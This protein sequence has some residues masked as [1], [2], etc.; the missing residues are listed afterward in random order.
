MTSDEATWLAENIELIVE[1]PQ[2]FL[3]RQDYFDEPAKYDFLRSIASEELTHQAQAKEAD[4]VE[5]C[6]TNGLDR[7][8]G[9]AKYLFHTLV[10]TIEALAE[11]FDGH[12]SR[13]VDLAG[14]I[15]DLRRSILALDQ[16]LHN[17]ITS[18]Q[19]AVDIRQPAASA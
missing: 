2:E 3:H 14:Q 1:D 18:K 6:S 17:H 9:G 19:Q 16:V 7:T 12:S 13:L 4:F 10:P 11:N 8:D 5:W 15:A